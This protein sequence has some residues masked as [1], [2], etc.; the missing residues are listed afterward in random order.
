MFSGRFLLSLVAITS[1]CLLLAEGSSWS[2]VMG[3]QAG[4]AFVSNAGKSKTFPIKNHRTD[5]FYS[6]SPKHKT[7]SPFIY[8][9][10]VGAKWRGSSGFETVMDLSYLQSSVFYVKGKLTQGA[11]E[12]SEDTYSYQY[13]IELRQ[14]LVEGRFGYALKWFHPYASIALGA[15]FNT[16]KHFSTSVPSSLT[17][18]REYS[19]HSTSA[20][21]YAVGAGMDFD[22]FSWLQLGVAYSFNDFGKASLGFATI[23]GNAVHGTLSQNH[24]YANQVLG[25]LTIVF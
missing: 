18:T 3:P 9:G 2:A 6:Y 22:L 4:I 19:S 12:Q 21:S 16:S 11:D 15:S 25:K 1:P 13:G 5:E 8:G 10:F 7:Q 24:L 17:F 20:F 14:L 23:D